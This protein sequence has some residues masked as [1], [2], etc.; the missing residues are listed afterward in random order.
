[1]DD[2]SDASPAINR[3]RA[4]RGFRATLAV[5]GLATI[6]LL[7][8]AC[9]GG[10]KGPRVASVGATTATTATVATVAPA[11]SS[12]SSG[13]DSSGEVSQSEQLQFAQCMRSHGVPD[14][15]DPSANEGTLNGISAAGINTQSP[16]Y[17]AALQA[18]E[19]YSPAGHLT[20]AQ[21]AADNAEGLQ[22]SECMRSHGVF[23]FPD[24][25]T[26]PTG[27]QA[28]NLGPEHIDPNSPTFQA[29]NR[30]CKR[31]VPGSK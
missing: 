21:T 28:I 10:S 8:A 25:I 12:G 16:A 27:G 15:P 7:A 19:K 6:G 4:R 23:N 3:R 22:F 11:G 13:P 24:P 18:C 26:G 20:P 17:Q 29:A 2:D 1:M 5:V 30:A 14:F 9:G 31:I